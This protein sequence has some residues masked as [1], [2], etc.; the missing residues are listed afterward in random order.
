MAVINKNG[1][2][3]F[4]D[5]KNASF[6][7]TVLHLYSILKNLTWSRELWRSYFGHRIYFTTNIT[8][9]KS[10]YY[11]ALTFLGKK[12]RILD[13]LLFDASSPFKLILEHDVI[14]NISIGA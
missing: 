1:V 3:A 6:L 14:K 9:W 10:S 7:L 2:L 8:G 13:N 12:I 5:A 11:N 4:T